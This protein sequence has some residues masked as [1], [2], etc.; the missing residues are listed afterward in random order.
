MVDDDKEEDVCE[1]V[2]EKEDEE[3]DYL[4]DKLEEK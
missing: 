4:Y 3:S 1:Y 2:M